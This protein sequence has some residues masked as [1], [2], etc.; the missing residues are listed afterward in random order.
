MPP[1]SMSG[2]FVLLPPNGGNNVKHSSE[3][4]HIA[5]QLLQL[6]GLSSLSRPSAFEVWL[7]K[8]SNET[9]ERDMSKKD[10]YL[11]DYENYIRA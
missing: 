8:I 5:V 7:S 1:V 2:F 9:E 4:E 6:Q 10:E 3:K 11:I